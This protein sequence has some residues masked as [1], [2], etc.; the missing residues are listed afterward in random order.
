MNNYYDESITIQ[1]ISYA[2][3]PF[4]SEIH[5]ERL[6]ID[7]GDGHI[8]TYEHQKHYS[9]EYIYPSEGLQRITIS[10]EKITYLDVSRLSL[11]ELSLERCNKLE[12]LDCS[13]NELYK[14]QVSECKAMEELLCNSNNLKELIISGANRLSQINASYNELEHIEL[15]SCNDLQLL[16]CTNNK[17]KRLE[18][19]GNNA[20]REINISNNLL[21]S[22]RLNYIF[23]QLPERKTTDNAMIFYLDNPGSESCD[24]SLYYLKK[25]HG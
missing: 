7:W 8:S 11:S 17:L 14:L 16:H 4:K 6:T 3:I 25:W 22:D 24:K 1:F 2:A 19:E 15:H 20:L 12:S 10:G 18:L 5:A 9:I 21:D 23:R 13:S